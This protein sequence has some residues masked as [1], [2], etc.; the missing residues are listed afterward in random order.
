M[1]FL[2]KGML[3]PHP[4]ILHRTHRKGSTFAPPAGGVELVCNSTALLRLPSTQAADFKNNSA[5]PK[6]KG[7][8]A[9]AAEHRGF[10]ICSAGFLAPIAAIITAFIRAP[11]IN[12]QVSRAAPA[13]LL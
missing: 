9:I 1:D 2:S 13:S 5:L 11:R 3:S 6:P 8:A 4:P 7:A 10:Q 12:Q